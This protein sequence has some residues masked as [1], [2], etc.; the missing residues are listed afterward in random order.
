[1]AK[2]EK[3]EAAEEAPVSPEAKA[4]KLVLLA[5]IVNMVI[6]IIGAGSTYF[7]RILYKRPA[8]TEPTERDRLEKKYSDKDQKNEGGMVIFKP[9]TL[10]IASK[11]NPIKGA[12][13][14]D[15]QLQGK[16]HYATIGFGM[17]IREASRKERIEALTPVITDRFLSMLGRK[18]MHE[19]TSVQGRYLLRSQLVDM[20]NEVVGSQSGMGEEDLITNVFFTEFQIQ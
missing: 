16:I 10:N 7:T 8:I 5:V 15:S 13:G 6:V 3:K 19:L 2:E 4:A 9:L 18:E 17:E 20:L 1:M 14:T 11:P 12:D